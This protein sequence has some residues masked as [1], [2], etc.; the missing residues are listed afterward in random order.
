MRS[1]FFRREYI[2]RNDHRHRASHHVATSQDSK[3]A[4]QPYQADRHANPAYVL[5][6]VS[7][8]GLA[9]VVPHIQTNL[10]HVS[11]NTK[12]VRARM[13]MG[14]R[15]M[16]SANT[17]YGRANAIPK[18]GLRDGE[19]EHAGQYS[20]YWAGFEMYPSIQG[21]RPVHFARAQTCRCHPEPE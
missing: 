5:Q 1:P 19:K 21:P 2:G 18:S 7:D 8:S 11:P 16:R 13:R 20:T 10:T 15:P 6:S 14:F 12:P 3:E 9:R 4:P 17:P